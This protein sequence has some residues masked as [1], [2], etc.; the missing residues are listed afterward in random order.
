MKKRPDLIDETGAMG[1]SCGLSPQRPAT[2][3]SLRILAASFLWQGAS[4]YAFVRAF[5]RAGHSVRAISASEFI[6]AWQSAPMRALRRLLRG[7]FAKEYNAVL[8]HEAENMRPDL[9]F[10]FKGT[11]V[12]SETLRRMRSKGIVCIQFF[13]DVSFRTHGHYLPEAL[14]HYDWIFTTKTFGLRDMAEQLGIRDSS[15]LPHSFDPETHLPCAVSEE[16]QR[17]YGCDMSFIG[18]WSPKKQGILEKVW[19]A[20]PRNKLKIWGQEYWKNAGAPLKKSFEGRTILGLEYAK[21]IQAS[22]INIAILSEARRGA[23]RGDQTTTRT[24][25]IPAA[26][27]FM[28]HERN[29]EA[30]QFFDEGTECAFFGD[31]GELIEKIRYYLEHEDERL[32]IAAAGR[33]RCLDSGY[34]V[35]ERARRVIEKFYEIKFI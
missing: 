8:I 31:P 27:G 29:D 28:L 11:Y 19:K 14:P 9:F 33:R 12:T 18:N 1:S 34:S 26:G 15:F 25:E 20:F 22:R 23:S 5:R 16:E 30:L 13:P 10:V 32:A 35:D 24:F 2:G 4:D 6:P 3:T 17:W 21:A 7:R